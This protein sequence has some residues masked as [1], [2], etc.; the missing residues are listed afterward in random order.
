MGAVEPDPAP[1]GFVNERPAR[2]TGA[3]HAR[4]GGADAAQ[5]RTAAGGSRDQSGSL[6]CPWCGADDVE[7]IGAFGAQLMSEQYLCRACRSPFERVRK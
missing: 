5:A 6:R 4:S 2:E 7:R 1:A 3:P